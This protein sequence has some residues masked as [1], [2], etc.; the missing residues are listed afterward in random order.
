[1]H[2]VHTRGWWCIGLCRQKTQVRWCFFFLYTLPPALS[3][4]FFIARKDL[5]KLERILKQGGSW[6]EWLTDPHLQNWAK[7]WPWRMRNILGG[8]GY[9]NGAE[10]IR[11]PVALAGWP[12]LSKEQCAKLFQGWND[13]LIMTLELCLLH[14]FGALLLQSWSPGA[15]KAG[16]ALHIPS[17]WGVCETCFS[18]IVLGVGTEGHVREV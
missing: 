7:C 14:D 6:G 11:L 5:D 4:V 15:A 13:R 9:Q 18:L 17:Q 2:V 1:M 8:W 16:T 12:R 3:Q 10:C